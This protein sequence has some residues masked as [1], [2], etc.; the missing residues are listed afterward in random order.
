[1]LNKSVRTGT[2]VLFLTLAEKLSTFHCKY[3]VCC[4]LV[5]YG[6]Y[7]AVEH[8][9]YTWLVE[10]FYHEFLSNIFTASIEVIM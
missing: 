8:S 2:L 3:D 7:Y 5:I 10:R 6:L 1:M 4:R 9:F